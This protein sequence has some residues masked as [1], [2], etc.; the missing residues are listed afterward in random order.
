MTAPC[1]L[2]LLKIY[3]GRDLPICYGFYRFRAPCGEEVV[4]VVL[5]DLLDVTETLSDLAIREDYRKRFDMA[6]L[7]KLVRGTS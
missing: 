3:Q 1:F 5:E 7:D 6:T 4:G 2:S